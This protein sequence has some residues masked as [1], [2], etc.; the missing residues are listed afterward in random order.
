MSGPR[1]FEPP[2]SLDLILLQ[3]AKWLARQPFLKQMHETAGWRYI[4]AL[5]GCCNVLGLMCANLVSAA[6]WFYG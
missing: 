6:A 2:L 1:Q 5:A 3:A 4:C